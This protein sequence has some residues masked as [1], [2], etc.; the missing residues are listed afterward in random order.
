MHLERGCT[1]DV[2]ADVGGNNYRRKSPVKPLACTQFLANYK[3]ALRLIPQVY[4]Y[5]KSLK[6]DA[7]FSPGNFISHISYFPSTNFSILTLILAKFIILHSHQG[8]Y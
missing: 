7:P 2:T 3:P 5:P 4:Y 1:A 8:K 6:T